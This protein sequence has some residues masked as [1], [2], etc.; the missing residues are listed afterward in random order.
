MN[1]AS[2]QEFEEES[3]LEYKLNVVHINRK[4]MCLSLEECSKLIKLS[5]QKTWE[6]LMGK[7]LFYP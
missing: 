3:E 4:L 6:I 2:S 5:V 1:I 7:K